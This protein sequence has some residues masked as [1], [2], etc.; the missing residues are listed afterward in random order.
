MKSAAALLFSIMLALASLEAQEATPTDVLTGRVTDLAGRPV[1]DAQVDVISPKS[2]LVRAQVTDSTGRYR[3]VFPEHAPRYQVTARRMGFSPIQRTV[4]SG[5]DA[6]ERFVVDLQFVSAPVALSMVEV[7]GDIYRPLRR[8]GDKPA[9]GEATVPNPVAEILALKDALHLSAVQILG[10]TDLAD[11]L[12]AKNSAIFRGITN[13]IAKQ[14]ETGDATQMAG[15]VS[16]MLQEASSNSDRAVQEAEKL[17]RPD[18]WILV[19]KGITERVERQEP[20]KGP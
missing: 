17:L 20:K 11:S 16:L 2:G 19:P 12:Q 18:Q 5:S 8:A 3:I 9:A 4:T 10:L 6:D 15:T 1:A 7:T 14:K 13:L